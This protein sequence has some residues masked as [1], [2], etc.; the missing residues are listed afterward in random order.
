MNDPFAQ[1]DQ[2][3]DRLL[4]A[5]LVFSANLRSRRSQ[6][7]SAWF[8]RGLSL[9]ILKIFFRRN[10][11]PFFADLILGKLSTSL[12]GQILVNNILHQIFQKAYIF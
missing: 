2:L 1:P 6:T 11:Q 12:P 10:L 5:S 8:K 7:V 3:F 9:F 4:I